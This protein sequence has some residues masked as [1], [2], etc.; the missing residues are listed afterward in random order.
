MLIEANICPMQEMDRSKPCVQHW[1]ET[2]ARAGHVLT[3]HSA[4][5]PKEWSVRR[6]TISRAIRSG[7][8]ATLSTTPRKILRIS[9]MPR[10]RTPRLCV[11]QQ[12]GIAFGTA[13]SSLLRTRFTQTGTMAVG[14]RSSASR[15]RSSRNSAT[16]AQ[17][18][19]RT[20]WQTWKASTTRHL[21]RIWDASTTRIQSRNLSH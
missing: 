6:T 20:E 17:C 1:L 3:E 2:R 21:G 9:T 10:P 4:S 12:V 18:L 14:L 7:S 16:T 15:T 11:C 13:R 5:A 8:M 19:V